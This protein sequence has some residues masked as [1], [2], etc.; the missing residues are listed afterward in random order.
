M[1]TFATL[2]V[3]QHDDLLVQP[4]EC[5][6]TLFVVAFA[7]VFARYGE[8]VPNRLAANEIKA[9]NL[10]VPATLP[11]VPGGNT[12]IVVTICRASKC[13]SRAISPL[14]STGMRSSR[15]TT[16]WTL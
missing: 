7:N 8:V 12:L 4:P 11:F 6:E 16:T 9:M 3:D 15:V 13:A 1:G 10:D 5:H 2:G 14:G